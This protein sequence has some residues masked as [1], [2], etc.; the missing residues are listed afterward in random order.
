[1]TKQIE[2]INRV[3]NTSTPS[4]TSTKKVLSKITNTLQGYKANRYLFL[5]FTP[6]I[7]W[8]FIFCYIPMYGVTLA[9]KDYNL[10]K[11][12][13]RSPWVGLDNFKLMFSGH[14]FP[15]VFKNTLAISVWKLVVGFPAPIILAILLNEIRF[16]K[17]KKITQ[18][19][20]YLPHFVSWVILGG[21]FAQILSP[22][23][24][25]IGYI[26]RNLGM[27]PIN[28]LGDQHWFRTVLVLTSL[29]KG[30]GWGSIIYLAS[31]A[32]INQEL[33]EA[34]IVD[35]A[36]RF[37]Q[38]IH[39][40]LPAL[41]PVV[42]ILFIL[43][44]GSIISDDFDQIFNLYSPVV[45]NV[46][47][48]ISTYTYRMGLVDMNYSYATAVGLFRNIISF[49]LIIVTNAIVKRMSEYTIW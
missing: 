33:Y 35:G 34:A 40:T 41:V 19:I 45:Y 48:V 12:I 9:F 16:Q 8:Y 25:P 38:V 10:V 44:I 1:M 18:T 22:S 47:D 23:I 36:S 27:R 42:T 30:I 49:T 20:S 4:T 26:M 2:E 5:I 29:W 6:V 24:G 13:F 37:Q 28:F 43:N 17:F 46:A 7:V 21:I 3:T 39:V 31:I 32:G 14:S 11:G 15:Q